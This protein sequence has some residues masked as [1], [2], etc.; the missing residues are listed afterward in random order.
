VE[1]VA[2][3]GLWRTALYGAPGHRALL[4]RGREPDAL[5]AQRDDRRVA[6]GLHPNRLSGIGPVLAQDK[7]LPLYIELA[8]GETL[9][10]K[11]EIKIGVNRNL[12]NGE[13]DFWYAHA[14][15]QVWEPL[16]RYD[17]DFRLQPGLAESW[18][19]SEDG[20]TWTFHLREDA[21]FS[22]G[23]PYT[24]A[25]LLASIEHARA[26]SGRPSLFLG[27]INLE[28]IY[29]NHTSVTAVDDYTVQIAYDT[30]RPLLPYSIA[31]HYSAQFIETIYLVEHD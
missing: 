11:Q 24:S 27:G 10:E 3:G 21:V 13:E 9:A 14:S 4:R 7:T 18:E 25:S 17:N 6:R 30:P 12:V 1:V 2:R 8:D 26:S 20:L 15:L 16:I 5:H 31:N 22:N 23:T 29:G 28:E 19:L